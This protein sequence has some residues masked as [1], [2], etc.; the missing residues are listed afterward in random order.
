MHTDIKVSKSAY[1]VFELIQIRYSCEV[2]NSQINT[3]GLFN[4]GE[5]IGR[6]CEARCSHKDAKPKVV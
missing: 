6:N 3:Q 1:E 5:V 4:T 2:E